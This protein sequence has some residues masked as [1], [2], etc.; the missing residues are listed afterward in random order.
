MSL[1]GPSK[2]IIVEPLKAPAAQ[3]Q[4]QPAPPAPAPREPAKA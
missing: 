4:P 1:R 3:P 2:T